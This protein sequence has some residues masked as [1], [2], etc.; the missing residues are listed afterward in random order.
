MTTQNNRN[1][2]SKQ[3]KEELTMSNSNQVNNTNNKEEVVMNRKEYRLENWVNLL[4][5][6]ISDKELTVLLDSINNSIP[7]KTGQDNGIAVVQTHRLV[8]VFE[9]NDNIEVRCLLNLNEF[10]I[11]LEDQLYGSQST[12]L[13]LP[14]NL[15][16]TYTSKEKILEGET[17]AYMDTNFM[18]KAMLLSVSESVNWQSS[19]GITYNY[20]YLLKLMTYMYPN[21]LKFNQNSMEAMDINGNSKFIIELLEKSL[22]K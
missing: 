15:H 4:E 3:N 17:T 1:Q 22:S 8:S 2:E 14:V 9:P 12:M 6:S 20:A 10:R 7:K 19:T 16:F 11:L 21:L 5:E 13:I 18:K